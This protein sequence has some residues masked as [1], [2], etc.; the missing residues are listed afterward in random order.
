MEPTLSSTVHFNSNSHHYLPS[1]DSYLNS[2]VRWFNW[3]IGGL[4]TSG[5]NMLGKKA[6]KNMQSMRQTFRGWSGPLKGALGKASN[7]T[8]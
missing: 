5:P 2:G 3:S 4:R 7:H 8:F 6:S 1:A